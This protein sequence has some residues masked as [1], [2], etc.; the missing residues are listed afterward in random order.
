[1]VRKLR[2]INESLIGYEPEGR[3]SNLLGALFYAGTSDING[4][5]ASS[6][7]TL[8]LRFRHSPVRG[9]RGLSGFATVSLPSRTGSI[10]GLHLPHGSNAALQ[11]CL[12][13]AL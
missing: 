3:G 5:Q 4:L 10:T 11:V 1:M 6:L 12:R 13:R 7:N 9:G 8:L 2:Q